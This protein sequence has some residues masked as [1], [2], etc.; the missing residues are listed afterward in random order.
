MDSSK[1]LINIVVPLHG[2]C[3][4]LRAADA[5]FSSVLSFFSN[6]LQGHWLP[7]LQFYLSSLL[8]SWPGEYP[9]SELLLL[10]LCVRMSLFPFVDTFCFNTFVVRTFLTCE[11]I[12]AS[13]H[14][15]NVFGG[16]MSGSVFTSIVRHVSVHGKQRIRVRERWEPKKWQTET[17][18]QNYALAFLLVLF[19][20]ES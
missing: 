2:T 12:L 14:N 18:G 1:T 11:N 10:F 17:W 19:E 7:P 20:D 13:P 5:S 3:S 16:F 15:L 8:P 9:T 6:A 4:T